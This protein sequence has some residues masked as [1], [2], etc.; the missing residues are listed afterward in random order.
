LRFFSSHWALATSHCPTA[1]GK[2]IEDRKAGGVSY[3]SSI[4]HPRSSLFFGC[5]PPSAGD[6]QADG[7]SDMIDSNI[8]KR[9]SA[10]GHKLLKEFGPECVTAHKYQQNPS[11]T[12]WHN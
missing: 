5:E 1:D 2:A 10:L 12:P 4:F 3:Q 9:R 7:N 8:P 6:G 11:P